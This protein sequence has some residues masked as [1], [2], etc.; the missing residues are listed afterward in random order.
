[1]E[2]SAPA[3]RVLGALIE[4]SLATPQGYPLSMA[5]LLTACN[6]QTNRDPVTDHDERTV[7]D[8]LDELKAAD[9]VRTVYVARS[10]TPKYAH[11]A[12]DELDLKPS[13]QAL[14]A[15]LLLRGPQTVGE[16][17]ARSERLHEFESLAAVDAAL[18]DL[19]AHPYQPLLAEQPR[20]PGQKEARFAH[21]L[22]PLDAQ[23]QP[24]ADLPDAA[25]DL[26]A[27]VATLREEVAALRAEVA[28]VRELLA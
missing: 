4:K 17:R 22:S 26:R 20:R 21:L 5:A 1:M 11:K 18:R 24:A 14:L 13:G 9:L 25:D 7:R 16:L 15:V 19:A 10:S 3:A 6:Q 27:A 2:L 12:A 23:A 28:E 8:A